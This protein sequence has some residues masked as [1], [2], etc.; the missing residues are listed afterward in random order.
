MLKFESE[1][2]ETDESLEPLISRLR[3]ILK[4]G[5]DQPKNPIMVISLLLPRL[6][7]YGQNVAE[8]QLAWV[9]VLYIQYCPYTLYGV[10]C[11]ALLTCPFRLTFLTYLCRCTLRT[12]QPPKGN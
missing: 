5:F 11:S 3:L 10:W 1:A 4:M 6:D 12:L 8:M 9:Q 7:G 2:M